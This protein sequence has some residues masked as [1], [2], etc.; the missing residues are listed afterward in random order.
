MPRSAAPSPAAI[1][2]AEAAPTIEATPAA[3]TG[4]QTRLTRAHVRDAIRRAT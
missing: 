3:V 1:T 2:A 4:Y